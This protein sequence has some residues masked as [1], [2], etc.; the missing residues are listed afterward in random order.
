M[1]PVDFSLHFLGWSSQQ[2]APLSFLHFF[3]FLLLILLSFSFFSFCSSSSSSCSSSSSSSSSSCSSSPPPFSF[4]SFCSCCPGEDIRLTTEQLGQV[5]VM[6]MADMADQ[7]FSFMDSLFPVASFLEPAGS[8]PHV[9]ASNLY[10]GPMM[11]GLFVS[12]LSKMGALARRLYA[13]SSKERKKE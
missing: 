12:A 13:R 5:L 8:G 2:R 9:N 11:P 7:H 4:F 6:T 10:P 3:S 1:I